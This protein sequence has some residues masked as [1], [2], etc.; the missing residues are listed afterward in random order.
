MGYFTYLSRV[1]IRVITD[2][3]YPLTLTSGDIQAY[4]IH[5]ISYIYLHKSLIFIS[6][7]NVDEYYMDPMGTKPFP[8]PDQK[9]SEHT[10]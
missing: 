2:W 7:V 1:Y 8:F 10:P 6:M 4:Y 9:G 5:C 3:A